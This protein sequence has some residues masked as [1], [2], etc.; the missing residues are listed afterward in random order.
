MNR[1][2]VGALLVAAVA[3]ADEHPYVDLHAHLFMSQGLGPAFRGGIEEPLRAAGWDDS[4]ASQ[5]NAD[6]L[7][8]SEI[9]LLVVALYA[10]RPF[11]PSPRAAVREQIRR[12]EEFTRR[13]PEW[14]IVRSPD[15]ARAARADGKRLLVLALEGA[16]G[17]LESEAD[18]A[19][20]V[21][22]LGIRIVTLAH[23]T[24][25]HLGEVAL[26]SGWKMLLAPFAFVRALGD[27]HY[28]E[29][30]LVNGGGLTPAGRGVA[31]ALVRR[32]VW[33]DLTHAPDLTQQELIPLLRANR[34][35]LLYTHTTLRRYYGAERGIASWQLDEVAASHGLVGLM[36]TE[37]MLART[38]DAKGCAG[39]VT[40][41]AAHFAEVAARIGADATMIGSD[42]NG[43]TGHLAPPACA[44]GSSLDA[45]G[46]RDIGQTGDL[47]RALARAGAAPTET[48][49]IDRFLYAW[50]ILWRAPPP[51]TDGPPAV[52]H[53]LP[54]VRG[55]DWL[56]QLFSD[57]PARSRRRRG[58][59]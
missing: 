33:I 35:P 20:F 3:A 8:R 29:G 27:P 49:A 31:R 32:R 9:G 46:L 48:H 39:S 11:V 55:D 50:D 34:Q 58:A 51:A 17:V 52:N 28:S 22:R 23:L 4:F 10:T 26:R 19:E 21:D 13:H 30:V 45:N 40:A 47:W 15:E 42:F 1:L 36:P 16:G 18:L 7:A 56:E 2:A 6:S 25:D 12:T 41:L 43:A 38:P 59:P 14:R 37:E 44:T 57:A 54:P 53:V 24:G 5:I